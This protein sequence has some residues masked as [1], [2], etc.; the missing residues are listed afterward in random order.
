M[1]W[2]TGPLLP[3]EC[4][5]C[6]QAGRPAF[7]PALHQTITTSRRSHESHVCLGHRSSLLHTLLLRPSCQGPPPCHRTYWS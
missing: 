2:L 6:A 7:P 1:G 4:L 5:Q 3:G